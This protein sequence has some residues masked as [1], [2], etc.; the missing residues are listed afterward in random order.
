MTTAHNPQRCA[1]LVAALRKVR[2]EMGWAHWLANHKHE[3]ADQLEAATAEV[4]GLRRS[5]D[6]E[7]R[8]RVVDC[9]DL[10]ERTAERDALRA[11]V[12]KLKSDAVVQAGVDAA[13]DLRQDQAIEQLRAENER[14]RSAFAA[15]AQQLHDACLDCG[16]ARFVRAQFDETTA[17]T[18][19]REGE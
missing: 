7:S 16:C 2:T 18:A 19:G 17:P 11:E 15:T 5:L 12:A 14:L 13:R 8:D 3:L 9:R 1:E 4:A 6:Q 10:E